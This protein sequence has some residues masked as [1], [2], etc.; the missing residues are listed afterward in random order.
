[1]TSIDRLTD[2]CPA[3]P[4]APSTDWPSTEHP[5][6]MSLPTD[7]KQ[8]ADTYGPGAFCS[9]IHLYHPHASTPW[10][11]ITG[12]MPSTIRTQ[13]QHDRDSGTYPVPYDPQ[14]LFV[15]GVTDNG[16]Y[17]FWVTEPTN[18]PE[19]WTIAA[20][21]AR[22]PQWYTYNGGLAA[23]LTAVLSGRETVPLFPDSL[24]TQGISFTP[25]NPHTHTD[26]HS[27]AAADTYDGGHERHP[28]LGTCQRLRRTRPRPHACRDPRRLE[29]SRKPIAP[30]PP[31]PTEARALQGRPGTRHPGSRGQVLTCTPATRSTTGCFGTRA[32]TPSGS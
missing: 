9:I 5:L 32:S 19:K 24:V 28:R 20:N 1:M 14:R 12:S 3:P 22:G 13:L 31:L 2:L 7:Y 27:A 23:F 26:R 25:H 8:I 29:E 10:T 30:A 21:E 15:M 4:T 11:S 17:L 16:E 6:G 18:A